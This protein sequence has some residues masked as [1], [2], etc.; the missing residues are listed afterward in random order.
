M[1]GLIDKNRIKEI[2]KK[3]LLK[4]PSEVKQ[5]FPNILSQNK[6][7]VKIIQN[8]KY[9]LI[10]FLNSE[11]EKRRKKDKIRKELSSF[12]GL[13]VKDNVSKTAFRLENKNTLITSCTIKNMFSLSL[14]KDSTAILNNH[15]QILDTKKYGYYEYTVDLAYVLSF[16]DEINQKNVYNYFDDLVVY[17]IEHWSNFNE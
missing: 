5:S 4:V 7:S 3:R 10:V 9:I 13:I 1:T 17:S 11:E 2:I 14:G 6:I 16:G 15:K 12:P 8:N